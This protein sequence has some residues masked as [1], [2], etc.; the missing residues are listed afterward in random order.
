MDIGTELGIS[1][2]TVTR[3]LNRYSIPA[4]PSGVTSFPQMITVLDEGVPRDIRAAVDG[5]L[6]GWIRL[7]R[8]HI[9]MAFPNIDTA[10]TYLGAHPGTLVHQFQRLERDI[11]RPL[12]HRSTFRKPHRPTPRGQALLR[13]LA[14]GPIQQL[15]AAALRHHQIRP[16]PDA[17]TLAEATHQVITKP[18]K[19][20]P[21]TPVPHSTASRAPSAGTAYQIRISRPVLTV[22][23]DIIDHP[24]QFY[25]LE[26]HQRTGIDYGTLYPM[27]HRMHQAG[28]LTSH[29]EDEQSWL[30]GAPPGRGPGRRRTYYDLTPE[31]RRAALHELH[32][33]KPG[34]RKKATT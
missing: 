24:G 31:G 2:E 23:R 5:A 4:R 6:H 26:L 19:T 8:F 16:M 14:Q 33:H 18:R 30:A 9:A 22:L 17:A 7:H 25:G 32:Q 28:W 27:L 34:N 21:R 3:N 1:A 13:D 29:P 11:G 12:F 20:T 10:A 15:M